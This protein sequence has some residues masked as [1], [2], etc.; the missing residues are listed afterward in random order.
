MPPRATPTRA[1][2]SLEFVSVRIIALSLVTIVGL[3]VQRPAFADTEVMFCGQV[4]ST[5]SAFLSADL[6]C[7]GSDTPSTA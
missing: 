4:I 7:T 3:L 5:G 6:D 1:S 2:T